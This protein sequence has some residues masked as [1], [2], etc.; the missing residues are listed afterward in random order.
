MTLRHCTPQLALA[1][2]AWLALGAAPARAQL[3]EGT[4]YRTLAPALPTS[5][6]GKIEVTEFFSYACPHCGAFYPVIEAW[7][8][9]QAKDVV[10]KRIPVSFNRAPW[11]NLQRAYYAMQ[12][13]GDLAKLDGKLF[14]AI[15]DEHL[16]LF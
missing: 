15:H 12:A 8:A 2:L 4:D 16:Q 9:K 1:A 3:V 14:R 10:L 6:P 7:A 11:I 5:S 13:S